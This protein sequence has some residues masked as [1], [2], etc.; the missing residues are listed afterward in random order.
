MLYLMEHEVGFDPMALA[1]PSINGCMAIVYQTETGLYGYHNAGGTGEQKERARRFAEFVKQYNPGPSRHLYGTTFRRANR[2]YTPGLKTLGI[3]P[4]KPQGR[5]QFNTDRFSEWISEMKEFADKLNYK[6][7]ISGVD[8]DKVGLPSSALVEYRRNHH[9]CDIFC[10][11]WAGQ[12]TV[13]SDNP[14]EH[15]KVARKDGM[16]QQDRPV[17]GTS[18]N[19]QL[20]NITDMADSVR[21]S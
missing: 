17:T 18:I 12:K 8:L 6:G 15:L 3:D 19:H 20:R 13:R 16:V 1:F 7:P 9:S 10:G 5:K 4:S 2:G 11:D 21:L 14:T